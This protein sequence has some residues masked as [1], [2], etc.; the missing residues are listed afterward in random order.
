MAC[1]LPIAMFPQ[2]VQWPEPHEW[3]PAALQAILLNNVIWMW[4]PQF[5]L[6]LDLPLW[7]ILWVNIG[8]F[9]H[10]QFRFQSPEQ[11]ET[12]ICFNT[13]H[14]TETEGTGWGG[15]TMSPESIWWLLR[16][17]SVFQGLLTVAASASSTLLLA[18]GALFPSVALQLSLNVR[19]FASTYYV[20]FCALHFI[21]S[22]WRSALF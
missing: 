13:I 19:A 11:R 7:N 14:F 10:S 4:K 8:S 22:F 17:P 20:L 2:F 1:N 18:L 9:L 3:I 16:W 6:Y 21:V 12:G 15:C 5:A